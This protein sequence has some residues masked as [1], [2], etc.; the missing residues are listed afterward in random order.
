MTFTDFV[1]RTHNAY[2]AT[3]RTQRQG[4]YFFNAL[5]MLSPVLA[6]MCRMT[7]VDPFFR[8]DRMGAF[9]NWL[10]ENWSYGA[11]QQP[12]KFYDFINWKG[13]REP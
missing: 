3:D 4:Q 2:I 7:S 8:N 9:L 13:A 12:S 6:G 5:A 11:P 1:L 10:A